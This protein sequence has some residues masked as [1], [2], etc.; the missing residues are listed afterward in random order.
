MRIIP[1]SLPCIIKYLN[2]K[3]GKGNQIEDA[4]DARD[5]QEEKRVIGQHGEPIPLLSKKYGLGLINSFAVSLS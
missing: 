2:P 3:R 4:G 5:L 1:R